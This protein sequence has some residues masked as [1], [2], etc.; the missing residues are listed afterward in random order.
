M[1]ILQA[2]RT[3]EAVGR[4]VRVAIKRIGGAIPENIPPAEH[5]SPVEKPIKNTPQTLGS[6]PLDLFRQRNPR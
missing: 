5:I 1:L 6:A 3:H 2:I 4:E